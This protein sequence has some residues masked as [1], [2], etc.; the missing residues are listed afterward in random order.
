[1]EKRAGREGSD[2]K[3]DESCEH[4]LVE[5]FLHQRQHTD[6]EERAEAD[7]SDKHE[8]QAPYYNMRTGIVSSDCNMR[9]V[10]ICF[11]GVYV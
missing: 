3:S 11:L 7:S 10:S 6:S 9:A 1:M 8:A 5:G 2:S 4:L